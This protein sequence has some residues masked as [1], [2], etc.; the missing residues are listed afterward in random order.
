MAWKR[1]RLLRAADLV[2]RLA[3]R[4]VPSSDSVVLHSSPDLDDSVVAILRGTPPGLAPTVLAENVESARARAAALSLPD[5]DLVRRRSRSGLWRFLRSRVAVS[6]HGLFGCFPRSGRKQV[7]GLWHGEFGKLIGPF[8]DEWPRPFDWMP[9]SSHL[10]RVM[11]SAEFQ[12]HPDRIHVV[13]APRQ[14]LLRPTPGAA[15]SL[16]SPLG[17]PTVV[18]APTYRQST[19]GLIRT[20]GDPEALRSAIAPTDPDLVA[21]LRRHGA[22]L[23]YRPHPAAPPEPADVPGVVRS[24]TNGDLEA[25]GLTLYE[26]LADTDVL[27]TDYSSLWVDY[28]LVDRPL[29]AFC[30]DLE[31]Y[32]TNRGLAL[33]PHE[34]WF[35]GPVTTTR[36]EFLEELDAALGDA[37]LGADRRSATRRLL[38]TAPDS[39]P[40][41][42]T[43]AHILA[44]LGRA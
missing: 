14:V 23:W 8:A 9:V 41:A 32:R 30:P 2:V 10:S 4:L 15:A 37:D 35:P 1:S 44:S 40:V 18:W 13:G 26:L 33:E 11:R 19:A 34:D 5:V 25:L 36:A 20:D 28:L 3:D 38:H 6:T 21:V 22:T 24:A 12:V 7:V 27:V 16:G 31:A 29:V 17:S 39:D 42:A 43:W